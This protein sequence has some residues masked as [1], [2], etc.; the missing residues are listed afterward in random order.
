MSGYKS[1]KA[2]REIASIPGVIPALR[3]LQQHGFTMIVGN[4]ETCSIE[5]VI[6]EIRFENNRPR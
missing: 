2:A 1:L 5:R 4:G 3:T 6:E